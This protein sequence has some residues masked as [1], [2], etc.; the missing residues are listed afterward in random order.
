LLFHAAIMPPIAGLELFERDEGVYNPAESCSASGRTHL[1]LTPV[2]STARWIAAG[3]AIETEW[4]SPLFSDPFARDLAGTE[5]FAML[6]AMRGP[7]RVGD[8]TTPDPY[9]SIR[10]KFF[11]DGLIGAVRDGSIK[12]V[13]ILAAGMDSSDA[14]RG[15]HAR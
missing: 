5:G 12:Q 4:T 15:A 6:V 2:G 3:R 10:T 11:D 7:D 1:S 8:A 14:D 13:L 9:F